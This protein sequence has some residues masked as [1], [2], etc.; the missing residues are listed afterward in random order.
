MTIYVGLDLSLVSPGVAVHNTADQSWALYGFAQRVRE[1]DFAVQENLTQ[2]HLFPTIPA[3][4]TNEC[5][6]EHIRRHI[7]DSVLAN[8]RGSVVVGIE[9]YAF[10]AKNSGSS[11]KLQEL[12]GIIKHSIWRQFPQWRQVHIPPSQWKKT[13]LGSGRAT[14]A[15][16]VDHV[17]HTGPTIS[18][19]SSLQLRASKN[20]DIPCP[21][22]D[23]ADAACIVLCLQQP[24]VE[25]KR[26]RKRKIHPVR[27]V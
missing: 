24:M 11:Y 27:V 25:Q 14:K 21:A 17:E 20:G 6:Y 22:Q 8:L 23:L 16:A 9:C 1:A 7:V 2:V 13:V 10:G 5:R 4:T 19:L 26:K 15:D 12:G 3:G 18:L